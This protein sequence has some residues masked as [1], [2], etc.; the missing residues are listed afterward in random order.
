L[1]E[2]PAQRVGRDEVHE[3]L[4]SVD[5]DDRDQLAIARLELGI[6]V[7]RDLLQLE[8]Q[9]LARSENGLA[10]TLAQVAASSPVQPD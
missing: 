2:L 5:L 9:L 4:G 7:D 1:C 3:R 10:G 8:S 6:A